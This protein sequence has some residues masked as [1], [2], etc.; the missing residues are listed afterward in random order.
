MQCIRSTAAVLVCAL[1][2][3]ALP[4]VAATHKPAANALVVD[5]K[6]EAAPAGVV[7]LKFQ[8]LF[9]LPVGERGLEPSEKLVALDGKRVRIVGYMVQQPAAPIVKERFGIFRM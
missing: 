9:K 2:L 1:I 7:D 5:H 3:S 8:E 6:L 4:C